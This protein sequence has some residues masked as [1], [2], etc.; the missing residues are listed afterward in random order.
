MYIYGSSL[1]TALKKQYHSF[2]QPKHAT[3]RVDAG[4]KGSDYSEHKKQEYELTS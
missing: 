4:G 3:W 2:R 1:C